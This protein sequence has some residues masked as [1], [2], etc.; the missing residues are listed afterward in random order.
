MLGSD[1]GYLKFLII[2]L[3]LIFGWEFVRPVIIIFPLPYSPKQP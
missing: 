3:V 2:E 1:W